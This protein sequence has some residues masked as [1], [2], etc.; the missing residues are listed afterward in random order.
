MLLRKTL[1]FL[2]LEWCTMH[3]WPRSLT[4]KRSTAK[5][6]PPLQNLGTCSYVVRKTSTANSRHAFVYNMSITIRCHMW[7]NGCKKST[8]F[9]ATFTFKKMHYII[10]LHIC[11]IRNSYIQFTKMLFDFG[12]FTNQTVMIYFIRNSNMFESTNA[13]SFWHIC[14]SDCSDIRISG[15]LE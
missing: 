1:D 4:C 14:K 13:A 5:D 6:S 3:M 7:R 12:T 8:Y 15:T 11:Y 2:I 10:Y 9:F